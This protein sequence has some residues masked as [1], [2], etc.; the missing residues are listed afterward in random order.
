VV[1]DTPQKFYSQKLEAI[2]GPQGLCGCVSS[3]T[4]NAISTRYCHIR[5]G[6]FVPVLKHLSIKTCAEIMCSN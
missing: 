6:K 1:N 2:V 5:M 3:Y 4:E